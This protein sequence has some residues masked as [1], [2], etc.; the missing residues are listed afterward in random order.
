M[1][2]QVTQGR[3]AGVA[4][5]VDLGP[6]GGEPERL[7]REVAYPPYRRNV[8]I[9]F[10]FEFDFGKRDA[11]GHGIRMD[12]DGETRA[13]RGQQCFRRVR[14]GVVS[15]KDMYSRPIW[16]RPPYGL[17]TN[18]VGGG[19]AWRE[20]WLS[21][22]QRGAEPPEV[23]R[24]Q[25]ELVDAWQS[26]RVGSPDYYKLGKQTVAETVRQMMHI[27]TVGEVPDTLP[28]TDETRE[29]LREQANQLGA[30][31]VIRL[32]DL[33]HVAVEDMRQGGDPRLPLE[34]AL[35]KVT[36]PGSDLSR[37]STAYRL[38]QLEQRGHA[39]VAV[40]T[41]QPSVASAPVAEVTAP[42]SAS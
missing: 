24:K 10:E 13:Q 9:P 41:K 37:E 17:D 1:G 35:V 33:L 7:G 42:P 3:A 19:L 30:P 32:I 18:P 12:A 20:W 14:R 26:T 23:Y 15:E 40:E 25:M 38:E 29:R 6:H 4:L 27:G 16:L 8:D 36:R 5:D 31:T 39:P 22:G 34:L 21:K 11:A 28:V 2:D